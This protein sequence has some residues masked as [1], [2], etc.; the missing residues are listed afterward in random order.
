MSRARGENF[1][2]GDWRFVIPASVH[3]LSSYLRKEVT[4]SVVAALEGKGGAPFRR[5]RHATTWKVQI[6]DSTGAPANIFVKQLDLAQGVVARAK[7][8][9]R[10]KR[11]EQVLRT[12]EA[13]RRDDFGVPDVL[14]IGENLA[15][16]SEVIV[17]AEAPGLMLTRWMNPSHRTDVLVRRAILQRLSAEIGRLHLSGYIHGDLTPYNIFAT[18]SHPIAITFIDHE[19]TGKT[20]RLSINLARNRLRNLVQLGHFDIPGVSRTDRLRVFTG[21]AAARGLSKS[22]SRQSLLRLIKMIERRRRRDRALKRV[23]T[24][25]AIIVEEGAARG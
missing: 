20:S 10:S 24:Q 13:L 17:M 15:T 22:A 4:G 12:A 25:P 7:A 3:Q 16:G 21:Y 8:M 23:A 5:S 18:G 11:S 19:G 6:A 9:L 2:L 14:L 1:D